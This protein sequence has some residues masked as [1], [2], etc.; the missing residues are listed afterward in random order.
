MKK[1]FILFVIIFLVTMLI[2]LLSLTKSENTS[3]LVTLFNGESS[4]ILASPIPDDSS[5]QSFLYES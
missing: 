2:P 4:I 5:R 3:E 1:A